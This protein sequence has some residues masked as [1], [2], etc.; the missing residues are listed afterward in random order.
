MIPISLL[1]DN[2]SVLV[3]GVLLLQCPAA[4]RDAVRSHLCV[5]MFFF[6]SLLCMQV[7]FF[8]CQHK[9]NAQTR[10]RCVTHTGSS[11]DSFIHRDSLYTCCQ[12][13]D[14]GSLSNNHR[15]TFISV[16]SVSAHLVV[17]SVA[18]RCLLCRF[19]FWLFMSPE[20]RICWI[21]VLWS[22]IVLD[23]FATFWETI[24][25]FCVW[26][27]SVTKS[28]FRKAPGSGC[29]HY[30]AASGL[31][32]HTAVW[33]QRHRGGGVVGEGW[34][35]SFVLWRI[36]DLNCASAPAAKCVFNGLNCP[37][38]R[39]CFGYNYNQNMSLLQLEMQFI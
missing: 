9:N 8:V 4:G 25:A 32:W 21:S 15:C 2:L 19:S 36:S 1:A 27:Y 6:L 34:H 17:T 22:C 11:R 29:S 3:F 12:N 7:S 13:C 35:C 18:S 14:D 5:M 28:S 10:F 37:V 38:R 30:P 39:L 26:F 20:Y 16:S 31:P 23:T 24:C 33:W